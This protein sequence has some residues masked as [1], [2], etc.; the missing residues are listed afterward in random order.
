MGAGKPAHVPLEAVAVPP[1]RGFL[2]VE[3][4]GAGAVL[5][6]GAIVVPCVDALKRT[7][8]PESLERLTRTLVNLPESA[9]T[10]RYVE[11]VAPVIKVHAAFWV[12]EAATAELQRSH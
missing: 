1:T 4:V 5:F 2:G 10:R 11:A 3:K 7:E 6:D 9:A 8:A 12:F